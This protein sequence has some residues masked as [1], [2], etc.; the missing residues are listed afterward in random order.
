MWDFSRHLYL[1]ARPGGHYNINRRDC[2]DFVLTPTHPK[3]IDE[4]QSLQHILQNLMINSVFQ[5]KTFM[6]FPN[7]SLD[8]P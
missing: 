6:L 3:I 5:V 2:S 4:V 1:Y 8:L 7:F